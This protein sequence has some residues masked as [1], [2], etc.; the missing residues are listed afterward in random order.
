[1]T[2]VRIRAKLSFY[3]IS[4]F[5]PNVD[6]PNHS[7]AIPP[8]QALRHLPGTT[9]LSHHPIGAKRDLHMQNNSAKR[10]S[11]DSWRQIRVTWDEAQESG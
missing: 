7:S 8:E 4:S 2:R 5:D 10:S 1:M 9:S 3:S 11:G 6:E